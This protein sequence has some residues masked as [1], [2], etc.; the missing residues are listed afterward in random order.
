MRKYNFL[1]TRN[2][3]KKRIRFKYM[4][5]IDVD[6]ELKQH[7]TVINGDSAT[8]KTYMYEVISQYALENNSDDIICITL[9]NCL[10]STSIIDKIKNKNEAIIIIDMADSIFS[11]SPEIKEFIEQDRKNYYIIMSR[12]FAKMYTELARPIISK[13]MVSIQYKMDLVQ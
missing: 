5:F 1:E 13:N 4:D 11:R 9:D 3:K 7:Y 10:D 12:T 6:I 8:G 2:I